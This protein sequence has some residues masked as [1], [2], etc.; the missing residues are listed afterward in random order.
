VK[1]LNLHE[2]LSGDY[3]KT[4]TLVGYCGHPHVGHLIESAVTHQKAF[5]DATFN[6][7]HAFV[8]EQE[9]YGQVAKPRSATEVA[10]AVIDT[11]AKA[12]AVDGNKV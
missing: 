2:S 12:D 9:N 11:S 6:D 10:K 4:K 8:F 3:V 1:T 7:R 5:N